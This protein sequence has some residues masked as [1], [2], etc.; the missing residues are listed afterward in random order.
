MSRGG[1]EVQLHYFFHLDAIWGWV[2]NGTPRPLY[3]LERPGTHC[4]GDRVGPRDGL[5]GH[6]KFR[7]HCDSTHRT[8]QP[9]ASRYS[10][11]SRPTKRYKFKMIRPLLLMT[12]KTIP[13]AQT[14][15]LHEHPKNIQK[16]ISVINQL[17]AQMFVL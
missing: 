9:V 4:I 8:V 3:P 7:P 11:L 17:N 6:E 10:A 12:V 14:K 16:L 5:D 13:S 1:V 2:V 15:M